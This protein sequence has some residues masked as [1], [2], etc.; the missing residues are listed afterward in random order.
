MQNVVNADYIPEHDEITADYK[1]GSK[2]DINMPDGSTLRLYKI[3][4]QY[5][6]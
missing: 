4:D 6:Q 5:D 3:D 1:P 2:E